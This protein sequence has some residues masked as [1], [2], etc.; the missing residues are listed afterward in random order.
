MTT[1]RAVVIGGS[2]GSIDPLR[3]L[4]GALPAGYPLAVIIVV[5]QH[6]HADG[7]LAE[8]LGGLAV[9]PVSGIE[10]K[11]S[12]ERGQ[13]YVGPASYH[14]LIDEGDRFALSVD[15]PVHAARPSLDVFFESAARAWGP[16]V[17][18]VLL[19][20]ASA[21]GAEGLSAIQ[22]RGGTVLCQ[23]PDTA[24]ARAMP[25]AGMAATRADLVGSPERLGIELR[26]LGR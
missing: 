1:K 5:H 14:V 7:W 17:V 18:G 13:I 10:D 23:H 3:V 11:Q 4:V 16:D 26:E 12:I 24:D 22:A 15:E 20:G 2:A 6:R 9:L 25:E 21:D 8:H 19:S